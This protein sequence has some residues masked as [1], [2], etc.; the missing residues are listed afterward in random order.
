[1]NQVKIDAMQKVLP[2]E[3]RVVGGEDEMCVSLNAM[4]TLYRYQTIDSFC[5]TH[6]VNLIED[7]NMVRSGEAVWMPI[8]YATE[9]V[10]RKKD[11]NQAMILEYLQSFDETHE[12]AE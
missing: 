8:G 5:A 4:A 11:L 3:K 9:I 7:V 1:M 2:V 10:K 12:V 6:L